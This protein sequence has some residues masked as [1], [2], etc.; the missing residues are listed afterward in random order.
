[1]ISYKIDLSHSRYIECFLPR[2]ATGTMHYNYGMV[3]WVITFFSCPLAFPSLSPGASWDASRVSPSSSW[4]APRPYEGNVIHVCTNIQDFRRVDVNS[5]CLVFLGAATLPDP[6]MET[7]P[8]TLSPWSEMTWLW[9]RLLRPGV[10]DDVQQVC[11]HFSTTTYYSCAHL[12]LY[13]KTLRFGG[14][15]FLLGSEDRERLRA[16][17]PLSISCY[18][19]SHEE[20]RKNQRKGQSQ[21][22]E[23]IKIKKNM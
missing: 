13:S 19:D 10:L 4:F 20:S 7:L 6:V 5:L 22:R 8:E 16:V 1:M 9:L 18:S 21:E 12:Y 17:R 11:K 15:R 23:K 2:H 14:W 3:S